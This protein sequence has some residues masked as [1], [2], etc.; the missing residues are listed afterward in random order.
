MHKRKRIKYPR[1][2]N[3]EAI[4]FI[5]SSLLLIVAMYVMTIM[6]HCL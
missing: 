3:M 6:A 1:P 5:A 2:M 4:K